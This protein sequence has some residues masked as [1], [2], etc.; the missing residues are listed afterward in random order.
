MKDWIQD[1]YGGLA[2]KPSFN[3]LRKMVEEAWNNVPS[4]E[5]EALINSMH[6]RCQAIIKADGKH[7]KF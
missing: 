2:D 5:L 1:V 4:D 7:T 6:S 3:S